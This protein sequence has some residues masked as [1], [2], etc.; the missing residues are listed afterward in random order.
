[1][2]SDLNA[3]QR[4]RVRLYG[5]ARRPRRRRHVARPRL[6]QRSRRRPRPPRSAASRRDACGL[7]VTADHASP[8]ADPLDRRREQRRRTRS[9][10]CWRTKTS[11][12]PTCPNASTPRS[13]PPPARP[14]RKTCACA[15]SAR[16]HAGPDRRART[17]PP[18]GRGLTEDALD[19]IEAGAEGRPRAVRRLLALGGGRRRDPQAAGPRARRRTTPMAERC[20]ARSACP[21]ARSRKRASPCRAAA[22]PSPTPSPPSPH[23]R[24]RRRRHA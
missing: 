5:S 20:C 11:R 1:M 23:P 12:R 15:F 6:R 18:R 14:K 22:A 17:R 13:P 4:H 7:A 19:R 16:A 10:S 3:L 21:P 9:T 24:P 2:T 8:A